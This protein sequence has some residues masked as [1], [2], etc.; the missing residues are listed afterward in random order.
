MCLLV[1]GKRIKAIKN[2]ILI[3]ILSLS[4][5]VYSNE[6][7]S[8]TT[9]FDYYGSF[10]FMPVEV[11]KEKAEKMASEDQKKGDYRYLVYG[12]RGENNSHERYLEKHYGIKETLVAGCIV[13][14]S[15]EEATNTY[16]STMKKFL[17]EKYRRDIF[18]ETTENNE[19]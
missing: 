11:A 16:N 9:K 8:T 19:L 12:L 4:S 18:K 10:D 17:T 3:I 7:I 6:A 13:T 14:E 2:I 15:A 1:S 5:S